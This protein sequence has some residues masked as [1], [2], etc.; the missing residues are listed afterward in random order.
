MQPS[1]VEKYWDDEAKKNN[2]INRI[3]FAH[4]LI[5]ERMN[6][7]VS[8]SRSV[9]AFEWFVLHLRS[10]GIKFPIMH[11]LSIGCGSGALERALSTYNFAEKI[12]GFDISQTSV[13]VARKMAKDAGLPGLFYRK[14][15]LNKESLGAFKCSVIFAHM[16][17][18]HIEN[19]E[20]FF[21][22]CSQALDD[23]GHLF[24]FEY[25]GPKRF[26]W[27][28]NQLKFVNRLLNALPDE[29]RKLPDGTLRQNSSM[30]LEKDMIA[31]DPSES[32]RSNEIIPVMKQWFDIIGYRPLRG[33]LLHVLMTDI[34]GNMM[35]SD[36]H[37]GYVS[38]LAEMEDI[39]TDAG[40]LDDHFAVII[41]KPK[42]ATP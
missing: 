41:A 19:L 11:A 39:L 5:K 9:D 17:V 42:R 29:I 13:D 12:T 2:I 14:A 40:M 37:A 8:G 4:P 15:D 36:L 31:D 7:L 38:L 18:H 26:Q 20:L 27:S 16:S 24:M 10:Q 35:K 25:I 23:D 33:A 34:T 3:W 1:A 30:P 6:R 28:E 22:G 21:E 32:V